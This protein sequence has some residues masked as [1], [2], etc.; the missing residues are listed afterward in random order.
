ML[1][2]KYNV[3]GNIKIMAEWELKQMIAFSGCYTFMFDFIEYFK[4]FYV[5]YV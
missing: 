1:E 5:L 4:Y 2:S 3:V